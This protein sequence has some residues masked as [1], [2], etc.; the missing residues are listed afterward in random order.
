MSSSL[1]SSIRLSNDWTRRLDNAKELAS[2]ASFG[3]RFF[4][5]VSSQPVV[6]LNII[7]GDKQD[8]TSKQRQVHLN[9]QLQPDDYPLVYK[10]ME[11]TYLH[12]Y[13]QYKN[14]LDTSIETMD[15]NSFS[16]Q[17]NDICMDIDSSIRQNHGIKCYEDGDA[18][19]NDAS[20][21]MIL[22]ICDVFNIM[23]SYRE[24]SVPVLYIKTRLLRE[25]SSSITNEF[26]KSFLKEYL[27]PFF[28][29]NIDFLYTCYAYYGNFSFVPIRT[30]VDKDNE[31]LKSSSFFTNDEH[32]V[33]H[34][35][36]KL[37]EFNQNESNFVSKLAYRSI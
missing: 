20:N 9:Y 3:S 23:Q 15:F 13:D 24:N 18:S 12:A 33:N 1:P 32:F 31:M 14:R 26:Q 6:S 29:N 30:L 4:L 2:N 19:N 16:S 22:H 7:T 25:V 17:F 28:W 27:V 11:E 8:N 21:V 34:Q 5:A 35:I 36:G 10:T 37:Q